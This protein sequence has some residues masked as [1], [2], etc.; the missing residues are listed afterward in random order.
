MKVVE[1]CDI[2]RLSINFKKTNYMIIK[3]AK[4]KRA[5]T[6]KVKLPDKEG[7]EYTLEEKNCIKYLGV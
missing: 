6:F 3:S 1:W 2:N 5:N 7:S 4:K